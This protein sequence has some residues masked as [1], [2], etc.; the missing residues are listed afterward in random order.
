V[1]AFFFFFFFELPLSS[2]QFL[3]LTCWILSGQTIPPKRIYTY[4]QGEEELEQRVE[5]ART[6]NLYLRNTLKKL[7][8]QIG[9]KET[10]ADSGMFEKHILLASYMFPNI[11]RL[12]LVAQVWP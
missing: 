1:R 8:R 12:L 4:E 2:T 5:E 9:S 3:V 7:E 10:L 11:Q 6:K